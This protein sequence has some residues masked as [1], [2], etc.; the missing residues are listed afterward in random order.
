MPAPSELEPT[1]TQRVIDLVRQAG[2]DVSDWSNYEHGESNPGANPKYCY[3]WA[4]KDPGRLVVANLWYR[5]IDTRSAEVERS[6]DLEDW[7]NN[8][9]EVAPIQVVRHDRMMAAL[10]EAY[11]DKLPVRVIVLK[12]RGDNPEG[13]ILRLLDAQAWAV[14]KCDESEIVLRRGALPSPFVDQ[15][16][17]RAA[18]PPDGRGGTREVTGTARIRDPGVRAY[19]L[20]RA[21]GRCEH[22]GEKGFALA[23][24]RMYLETHHIIALANDGPDGASNVIALCANDHREAHFGARAV[25]L[26]KAFAA[27]VRQ[28]EPGSNAG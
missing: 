19:V 22:C 18:T 17:L 13:P 25:E 27:K 26:A 3:E 9:D 7:P 4:L 16:S 14:V 1:R 20:S 10:R 23:D 12:R 2:L 8:D 11:R 28:L 24:G 6:W 21:Q 5:E 15:F